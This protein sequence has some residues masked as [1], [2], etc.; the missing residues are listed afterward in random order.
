[1]KT[2]P[3]FI[4][5]L[6]VCVALGLGALARYFGRWLK[7]PYTIV[8]L[9]AGLA[10]G[11]ALHSPSVHAS[12]GVLT[13]LQSG[14]SLAPDLIIFVFLPAL[15]FESAF[16]LDA[17]AFQKELGGILIFAI[18]ALLVSTILVGAWTLLVS[19]LAW[20]WSWITA[21][22]FGA[23]IS[24][25]DPVAVVAILRETTSPKRLGMLI[26][27]E[28]LM[29]DGT[30]I[31]VFGALMAVLTSTS[32]DT[33][34]FGHEALGFLW[35]VGGGVGVGLA[36]AWT[37]STL[38]ARTFNDATIE[39]SLTLVAA[40]G[41]MF[42]AEGLLHV[43]GVMAVVT[44]G[45]YLSGPGR[46]LISPEVRHFLHR[47]WGMVTHIANTLIFFLVGLVIAAQQ[48]QADMGDYEIIL[49]VYSGVIVL[50]FAVIFSFRPL[51]SLVA[52]PLGAREATVMAW[53]G[54][55]GA[56]SLALALIVSQHPALPEA[57]RRQVL[58]VTAG[59]VFLTILINGATVAWLLRKLGLASQ[60]SAERALALE[61]RGSLLAAVESRLRDLAQQPDLAMV[62]WQDVHEELDQDKTAVEE[63][64]LAELQTVAEASGADKL[65]TEW[66]QA[67]RI[68]RRAYWNAF[69]SGVLSR[70]GTRILDHAVALHFDDLASGKQAPRSRVLGRVG[71]RERMARRFATRTFF[72]RWQFERLTLTYDLARAQMLAAKRVIARMDQLHKGCD[73]WD[74]RIR[75]TYLRFQWQAKEQL[76]DLRASLPEVARA[77][78]LRLAHRIRLNLELSSYQAQREAGAIEA[79]AAERAICD[80]ERRMRELM[81][82][83]HRH[84]L[85]E[86]ANIV[87]SMPLF[88]NLDEE[89]LGELARATK[90]M[91]Y[92]PGEILMRDGE[93][94]DCMYV[95]A[96]G[97]AAVFKQSRGKEILLDT[98]GGGDIVGEMALLTGESRNATV[99]AVTTLAV[100]RIDQDDFQRIMNHMPSLRSSVWSAFSHHRF[101][102]LVRNDWRYSQM[103]HEAVSTWWATAEPCDELEAGEV[104]S[105]KFSRT[106]DTAKFLFLASGQLDISGSKRSAPA[107][108]KV[109][110][111]S[112][113]RVTSL[114]Y[115]VRLPEPPSPLPPSNKSG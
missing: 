103:S 39:I 4:A 57:L 111:H 52:T 71:L 65:R 86:T 36:I 54:L 49:G 44:T 82:A 37:V 68:E 32:G 9:L 98:L 30:A 16:D 75:D 2:G 22:V 112:V 63:S 106:A 20:D 53:G 10:I 26:E 93:S 31:V 104:A 21:L 47:F 3:E 27:G 58:L 74:D 105:P 33:V 107:L 66:N 69:A 78:E 19:G 24:A 67:C 89:A 64:R 42:I 85:P 35:V 95:I 91:F 8:V 38:I 97:A 11:A 55:R 70:E 114:A 87:R 41:A 84:S 13:A 15:V 62:P 77:I 90:E 7:L 88:Q 5:V 6:F 14:A 28:S 48:Q 59:V 83:P 80:I 102:N 81:Y 61:V 40:Y 101:D 25:T 73:G 109:E 23:L 60:S 50:R 100:G 79:E 115:L 34:D 72:P 99:R 110:E 12:A 18:P 92:S 29:N 94:S 46:T 43:S 45:L 96:R 1:M 108:L 76:E 113:Y 56:V 17:H 51:V